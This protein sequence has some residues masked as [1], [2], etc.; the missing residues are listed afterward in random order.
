M[1]T[2]S[3]LVTCPACLSH[4]AVNAVV[5]EGTLDEDG[6]LVVP[7]RAEFDHDCSGSANDL[8]TERQS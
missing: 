7:L 2:G 3:L 5:G 4:V 6:N 8:D 1:R